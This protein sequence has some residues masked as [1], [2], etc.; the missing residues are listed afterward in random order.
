MKRKTPK[1]G[2]KK[3]TESRGK[4][5]VPISTAVRIRCADWN[6]F[7]TEH[8]EN[9]SEGGIFILTESPLKP[10]TMFTLQMQVALESLNA[11]AQVIWTKEFSKDGGRSSGMGARFLEFAEDQKLTL[12]RWLNASEMTDPE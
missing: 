12:Q 2:A 9:I 1:K 10:G 11:T 7:R 6:T 8:A 4:R 3:K 5:R